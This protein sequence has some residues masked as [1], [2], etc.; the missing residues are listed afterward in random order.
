LAGYAKKYGIDAALKN[1]AIMVQ[2]RELLLVDTLEDYELTEDAWKILFVISRFRIVDIAALAEYTTLSVHKILPALEDLIDSGMISP[3]GDQYSIAPFVR[4]PLQRHKSWPL[5]AVWISEVDERVAGAVE[6]FTDEGI[7]SSS[8]LDNAI[9]ATLRLGGR[10]GS[11]LVNLVLG[12]HL[13]RVAREIYNSGDYERALELYREALT[14][15]STLAPEAVSEALRFVGLCG[16]RLGLDDVLASA[17]TQL[18]GLNLLTARRNASFL[19]GFRERRKRNFSAALPHFEESLRQGEHP[20]TLREAAFCA[21]MLGRLPEARSWASKGL[22]YAQTNSYFLNI[23]CRVV[24]AEYLATHSREKDDEFESLHRR[25]ARACLSTGDSFADLRALERAVARRE[26]ENV[27]ALADKLMQSPQYD[28]FIS[29]ACAASLVADEDISRVIRRLE[30]DAFRDSR[31]RTNFEALRCMQA[32][33]DRRIDD[34]V[35]WI[36]RNITTWEL[37]SVGINFHMLRQKVLTRARAAMGAGDAL[38][39]ETVE[40]VKSQR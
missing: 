20:H 2:Y 12:S 19:R 17:I 26:V 30:N 33:H 36:R 37:E 31:K 25:L 9:A 18:N 27:R 3:S 39:R 7:G 29:A 23:M 8:L 5:A 13:F 10:E 4:D 6:T 35:R 14:L 16:A 28:D 34:A 24:L 15:R 22:Q 11:P 40:F 1:D 38:D 21:L 32:L